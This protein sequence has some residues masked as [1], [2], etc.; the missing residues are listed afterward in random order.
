MQNRPER[1][2]LQ[3][4]ATQ[5]FSKVNTVSLGRELVRVPVPMFRLGTSSQNIHKIVKYSSLSF[6]TSYD[7][8]HKLFQQSIDFGQHYEKYLWQGPL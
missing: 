7:K 3:R 1:C 8:S 6:E 4:S 2:I 5:G